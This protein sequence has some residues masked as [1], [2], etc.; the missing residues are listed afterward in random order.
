MKA[1]RT[2]LTV[3]DVLV[4]GKVAQSFTNGGAAAYHAERLRA[5]YFGKE[6]VSIRDRSRVAIQQRPMF[7]TDGGA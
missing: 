6:R 7:E 1:Q 3:W 5:S 4:D 2:E